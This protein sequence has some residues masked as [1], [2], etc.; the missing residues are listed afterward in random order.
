MLEMFV[1]WV[2]D[3]RGYP[4]ARSYVN[5]SVVNTL[6]S[7]LACD[8]LGDINSTSCCMTCLIRSTKFSLMFDGFWVSILGASAEIDEQ[9]G[10][11]QHLSGV[12]GFSTL[13]GFTL[14]L[15]LTCLPQPYCN[16]L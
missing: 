3:T 6:G 9:G 2:N 5:L 15:L 4:S 11:L 16:S 10:N 1:V 7:V 12:V 13:P 8:F 14:L